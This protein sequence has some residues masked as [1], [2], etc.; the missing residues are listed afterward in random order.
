[1]AT[2]NGFDSASFMVLLMH[3]LLVV[4]PDAPMFDNV[5]S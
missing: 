3:G 1:M 4:A 5:A 2:D